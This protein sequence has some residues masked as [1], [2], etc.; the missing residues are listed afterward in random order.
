MCPKCEDDP[1]S[2]WPIYDGYGIYLTSVCEHCEE[3][4]LR[5]FRP[6]IMERY[7]VQE[8]IDFE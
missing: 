7:D 5:K 8:P 3:D 2:R 1:N 6:D 4:S